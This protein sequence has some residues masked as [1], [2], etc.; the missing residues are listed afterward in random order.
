LNWFFSWI[1]LSIFRLVFY[2]FLIS[3]CISSQVELL[4]LLKLSSCFFSSL[5]SNL[6]EHLSHLKKNFKSWSSVFLKVD[7][8]FFFSLMIYLCQL[9]FYSLIDLLFFLNRSFISSWNDVMIILE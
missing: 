5:A 7:Y 8:L 1:D 4:F 9:I 6:I 3:P 2:F